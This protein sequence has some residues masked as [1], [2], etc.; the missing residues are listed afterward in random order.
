MVLRFLH[1][2]VFDCLWRAL[3]AAWSHEKHFVSAF[4]VF[5][6]VPGKFF[7]ESI[8]Y[9]FFRNQVLFTFVAIM[10]TGDVRLPAPILV[11]KSIWIQHIIMWLFLFQ[12]KF[13]EIDIIIR[14]ILHDAFYLTV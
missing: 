7:R 1:A 6:S 9:D 4:I 13:Q 3:R 2:Y 12:F 11:V 14:L 10:I 8:L 5:E